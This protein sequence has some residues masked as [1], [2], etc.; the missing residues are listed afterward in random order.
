MDPPRSKLLHFAAMSHF[1]AMFRWH[2][3]ERHTGQNA[4][5]ANVKAYNSIRYLIGVTAFSIGLTILFARDGQASAIL[6]ENFDSPDFPGWTLANQSD[7]V[8]ATGWFHGDVFAAQQGAPNSFAAANF[9]NTGDIGNI[10]NWLIS[11][12]IPLINGAVLTFYTRTDTGSS[13]PDR[14]EVRLSTDGAAFDVG[15]TDT[16]VGNFT[17]L[18]LTVNPTL[19]Q[20][21]YPDDWT[22]FSVT[23]SGLAPSTSGHLAF[24]YFVPDSGVSGVNGNYIGIDTISLVDSS[25]FATPLPGTLPLFAGGLGVLGLLGWRRKR[26]AATSA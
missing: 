14:L 10:S 13:F 24:R 6:T 1:D 5:Y 21:G 25:E 8:G 26:K 23:L 15:S 7:P 3:G 19:T 16:S 18:L 9:N 17:T 12:T 4:M 2:R 11:D 22:L 20:D